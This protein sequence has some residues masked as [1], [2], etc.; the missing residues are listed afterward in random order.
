M[1]VDPYFFAAP[2]N[3]LQDE[4]FPDLWSIWPIDG[5]NIQGE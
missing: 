1:G 5:W 4:L 3:G 2:E